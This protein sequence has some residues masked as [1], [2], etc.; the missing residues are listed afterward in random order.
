MNRYTQLTPSTFNPLSLEEIMLVPT[1]KRKQHDEILA[2]NDLI[3][4]DIAKVDPDLK[5][6]TEAQN[7]KNDMNNQLSSVA[8]ELN[9]KG[10]ND[11]TKDSFR[12]TYRQ[13]KDLTSP[14]GKIGMINAHK[15]NKAKTIE[16]YLK[17]G[18]ALG[19]SPE[20]MNH[21]IQQATEEHNNDK[22]YDENGRV[23][24][25]K[26]GK[27]LVRQ[28]DI[29]G[30]AAKYASGLG[31]TSKDWGNVS[32]NLKYDADKGFTYVET[33]GNKQG[34]ADNIQQINQLVNYMN[35]LVGDKNSDYGKY[36]DYARLNPEDIKKHILNQSGIYRKNNT[37]NFT[38]HGISNLIQ[39]PKTGGSGS[40]DI[41]DGKIYANS[42]GTVPLG[43]DNWRNILKNADDIIDDPNAAPA[44]KV[45]AALKKDVVIKAQNEI[46]GTDPNNLTDG[47]KAMRKNQKIVNDYENNKELASLVKKVETSLANKETKYTKEGLNKLKE[48][49]Q[50]LKRGK[51]DG[52]IVNWFTINTVRT[53]NRGLPGQPGQMTYGRT[54][55]GRDLVKEVIGAMS[56][57]LDEYVKAKPVYEKELKRS[58]KQ[59]GIEKTSFTQNYSNNSKRETVH[60]NVHEALTTN[61]FK[62]ETIDFVAPGKGSN[63]LK[64]NENEKMVFLEDL[65]TLGANAVTDMRVS[66]LGAKAGVTVEYTVKEDTTIGGKSFNK[67]SRVSL[68]TPV[69]RTVNGKTTLDDTQMKAIDAFGSPD[70]TRELKKRIDG[71]NQGIVATTDVNTAVKTSVPLTNYFNNAPSTA[72]VAFH[73]SNGAVVPLITDGNIKPISMTWSNVLDNTSFSN[74]QELQRTLIQNYEHYFGTVPTVTRE[75][76]TVYDFNAIGAKLKN[77]PVRLNSEFDIQ[78]LN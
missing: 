25:F 65:R 26:V 41:T 61:N 2:K 21:W 36:V 53:K 33:K 28:K 22:L 56:T 30:D 62:P 34:R 58:L 31:L 9:A 18:A 11:L 39:D 10:I 17:D 46:L 49:Q 12:K 4:E 60:A 52:E 44:D 68:F 15:I 50:D 45:Q 5:Y 35:G 6:F 19:L 63:A 38:E 40:G 51:F 66:T 67:G 14:T 13:Y 74:Q 23:I 3:M 48:L 75:G 20:E 54:D 69:T 76:Q 37:S 16:T 72:K 7:I 78:N 73:K 70:L 55:L 77:K 64:L 42:D 32:A 1:L 57:G 27:N 47:Q 8:D 43:D 29:M 59:K 71:I 24:D